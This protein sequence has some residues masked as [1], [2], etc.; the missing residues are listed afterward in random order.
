M[1]TVV[2]NSVPIAVIVN[3]NSASSSEIVAACLKDRHRCFV[4]GVRSFG[5][6]SVQNVIPLEG[7]RAALRL[8]TAY[9]YPPSGHRIHRRENQPT[10]AWGVDPSE[11]C[12]IDLTEEELAKTIARFRQRSDPSANGMI[13][14]ST[15]IEPSSDSLDPSLN[16]DGQLL[17]AVRKLQEAISGQP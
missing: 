12:V 9:Y 11:G 13:P 16:D 1:G 2:P 8:T 6:G 10:D 15:E 14:Q 17:L 3:E 5:K 7:G 4:V